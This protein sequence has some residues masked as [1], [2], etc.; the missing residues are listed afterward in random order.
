MIKTNYPKSTYQYD[1]SGVELT[2]DNPDIR[3]KL[4]PTRENVY[5]I[6]E[7]NS[8]FIINVPKGGAVLSGLLSWNDVVMT[9]SISC[10]DRF[11][12][13]NGECV[14]I[15]NTGNQQQ[16]TEGKIRGKIINAGDNGMIIASAENSENQ[17]SKR[18][19]DGTNNRK[20]NSENSR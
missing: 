18:G 12:M 4:K 9:N 16:R 8:S 7:Q 2:L 13:K 20:N 14:S 3:V 17:A 1:S 6:N 10:L 11:V 5:S 15:G 19:W